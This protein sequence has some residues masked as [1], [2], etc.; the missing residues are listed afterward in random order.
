MVS[1][2]FCFW[3]SLFCLLVFVFKWYCSLLQKCTLPK[4]A[5]FS[6]MFQ[7]F[8]SLQ[9]C[10][11]C[12]RVHRNDFARRSK[13][14]TNHHFVKPAVEFYFCKCCCS[15]FSSSHMILFVTYNYLGGGEWHWRDERKGGETDGESHATRVPSQWFMVSTWTPAPPGCPHL[16]CSCYS[17]KINMQTLNL[18][19]MNIIFL[20]LVI[21]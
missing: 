12:L 11:N 19:A 20:T 17:M 7:G 15:Q 5:V 13:F 10:C 2:A 1:C 4:I 18:L 14:T 16:F 8:C 3:R 6:L 9:K 21:F